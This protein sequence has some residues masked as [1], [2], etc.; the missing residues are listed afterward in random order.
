MQ[1]EDAVGSIVQNGDKYFKVVLASDPEDGCGCKT[2]CDV[3]HNSEFC[4]SRVCHSCDREDGN[5]IDYVLFKEP[6]TYEE[7]VPYKEYPV[8][9]FFK[10]GN[11]VFKAV[12]YNYDSIDNCYVCDLEHDSYLRICDSTLCSMYDRLDGLSCSFILYDTLE[13][14]EDET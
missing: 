8:G 10:V 14:N 1:I 5:C 6:N 4:V 3:E 2:T 12:V 11:E 9:A 13:E 7:F